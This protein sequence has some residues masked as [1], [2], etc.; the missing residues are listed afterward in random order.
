MRL[1]GLPDF[2]RC[3]ATLAAALLVFA[4]AYAAQPAAAEDAAPT[5]RLVVDYG[6]GASKTINNLAW[7]KA[8][9]C[10]TR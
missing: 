5:V 3:T 7:A 1:P 6:D 10:S 2:D 9:G 8:T 4:L